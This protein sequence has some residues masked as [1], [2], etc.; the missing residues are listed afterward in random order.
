MNT[1]FVVD[2]NDTWHFIKKLLLAEE[3]SFF[4]FVVQFP[5]NMIVVFLVTHLT[6]RVGGKEACLFPSKTCC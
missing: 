3:V 6:D 5:Q 4:V 1:L 2:T